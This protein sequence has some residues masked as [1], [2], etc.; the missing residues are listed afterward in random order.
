MQGCESVTLRVSLTEE[1]GVSRQRLY[2]SNAQRQAA[3]RARLAERLRLAGTDDVAARLG[4]LEW[5]L[6]DA[7]RRAAA[8]TRRAVRAERLRT[9]L[10]QDGVT[11]ASGEPASQGSTRIGPPRDD[12]R[13]V[14][15]LQRIQI[16]E[17]VVDQLSRQLAEANAR[18]LSP[19]PEAQPDHDR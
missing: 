8:A 17:V 9:G 5:A 11:Q 15:A 7:E 14:D 18:A 10:P 3:Y 12:Q 1:G 16:L 4:Q 2:E 13:L 6:A 19:A